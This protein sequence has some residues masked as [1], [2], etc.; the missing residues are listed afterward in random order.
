MS[1]IQSP[2]RPP[3]C[4]A[5]CAQEGEARTALPRNLD[6]RRFCVRVLPRETLHRLRREEK[7]WCFSSR[8]HR[9][10]GRQ[11]RGKREVSAASQGPGKWPTSVPQA[12]RQMAAAS[13]GS[14]SAGAANLQSCRALWDQPRTPGGGGAFL[15]PQTEDCGPVR[16]SSA[17]NLPKWCKPIAPLLKVTSVFLTKSWTDSMIAYKH[18]V[19]QFFLSLCCLPELGSC[20]PLVSVSPQALV[21]S[22]K[23]T[24]S[25]S[26]H[27]PH[28]PPLWHWS[29]S[30][31]HLYLPDTCGHLTLT[32]LIQ[33]SCH[34]SFLSCF[35]AAL[36]PYLNLKLTQ[37]LEAG[38]S[39]PSTMVGAWPISLRLLDGYVDLGEKEFFIKCY[40]YIKTT[41]CK[42]QRRIKLCLF[43]DK[44]QYRQ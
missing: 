30:L 27:P 37:L 24:S 5:L 7:S 41:M 8:S 44:T 40:F 6:S 13:P 23:Y 34:P 26:Q 21:L 16:T 9:H 12:P 11:G 33:F 17:H 39:V 35:Q 42:L 36:N 29:H 22:E 3:P 28:P 19:F 25:G 14:C 38:T 18:L 4:K 43:Q 1:A 10:A 2:A 32:V 20:V 31:Y 15:V